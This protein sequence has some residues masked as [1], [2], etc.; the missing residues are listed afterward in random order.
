MKR[1]YPGYSHFLPLI[2]WSDLATKTLGQTYRTTSRP[3]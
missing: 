1:N 2:L 3:S